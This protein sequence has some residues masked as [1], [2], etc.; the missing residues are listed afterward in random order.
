MLFNSLEFLFFFPIVTLLYFALPSVRSRQWLL[1]IASTLFYMAFIPAYAL[2]LYGTIV[3]DYFAGLKIAEAE[4]P[5]RRAWLSASI[6]ANVGCL[7][8]FKY[9]NFFI[10]NANSL[11]QIANGPHIPFVDM[12][13]PVGLSFHTFQAMSY[14]IEVYRRNQK[15]ERSFLVYALYVMFYPQLVAGPIERPQNII[16]QLKELHP[17]DADRAT[18]GFRLMLWGFFKKVAVADRLALLVAPVYANPLEHS[19]P[20]LMVATIAFAIQIYADFSGYSDIAIGSADVMGVKLM[21]NFRTPYRSQSFSE[22][23]TRWHI[24]LSTWFRDYLYIP[25]GGNRVGPLRRR[26]NILITFVVSGLW[27]GANWTY[28][29]WG[30]LN[31]LFL[32]IE[33]FLSPGGARTRTSGVRGAARVALTFV[34]ISITWIFFRAATLHD[35]LTILTRL[36]TDLDS[37]AHPGTI[38]APLAHYAGD[39]LR[40]SFTVLTTTVLVGVDAYADRRGQHPAALIAGFSSGPRWMSYAAITAALVLFG[41]Y[42]HQQFIYF[43]F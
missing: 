9:C 3:V 27:H 17:F 32:I 36:P 38:V 16:N 31:G 26:L 7:A 24:S 42:G 5:R 23:W 11:L 14:T 22:F 37:L 12:I 34:L 39:L 8:V 29:I 21:T 28:V 19:G 43:Q 20:V 13:L 41:I 33:S 4:G 40:L 1:V 2:L 10:A 18:R 25:L 30:A 35:A 15:P 6:V